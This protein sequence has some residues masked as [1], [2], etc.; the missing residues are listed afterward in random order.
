MSRQ[1]SR[2]REVTAESLLD[3]AG[4]ELRESGYDDLTVRLV[5]ARAGVAPATAYTYFKSK[6]HLVAEAYLRLLGELP[7]SPG[8]GAPL[9]RLRML[10]DDIA[11]LLDAHPDLASAA[12]VAMLADQDEVR[13]VRDRIG[14][15]T[16]RRIADAL[17][18]A[19][20]DVLAALDLAWAGALMQ[21]GLGHTSYADLGPQLTSVAAL[22]LKGSR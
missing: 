10:F 13:R 9:E 19:P 11:K 18:D 6:Q 8:E 4:A 15:A 7:D 1:V 22:L 16:H 5:A 20:D 2:K 3:A 21:A 14:R 12:T 17:G